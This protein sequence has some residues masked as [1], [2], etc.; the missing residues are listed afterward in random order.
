MTAWLQDEG[1]SLNEYQIDELVT[2]IR[3]GDWTQIRELA[4]Q[5]GL[6]PPTL[7]AA[8]IDT[9]LLAEITELGGEAGSQW[10]AV[11]HPGSAPR[12]T[13]TT[14][15]LQKRHRGKDRAKAKAAH[16][17]V[18]RAQHPATTISHSLPM[19]ESVIVH[20]PVRYD[21]RIVIPACFPACAR[22]S[23]AGIH[24]RSLWIPAYCLRE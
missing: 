19:P 4:S 17:G 3:Y 20:P 14:P 22:T 7:P 16:P 12:Q 8:E 21:A 11:A 9:A 15:S 10:A 2:L 23:L 5:R 1:G 18:I 13:P 24:S 6:I